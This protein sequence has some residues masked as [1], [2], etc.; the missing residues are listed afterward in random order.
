MPLTPDPIADCLAVIRRNWTAVPRVGIVLGTGL[1]AFVEQMQIEAAFERG[2]LPHFP[3]AT[4]MS[5]RGRLVCGH[6]DDLPIVVMD[7]RFHI[8]EGHSLDLITLPVRLMRSMGIELLILTNASGGLNPDFHTGD[9]V[10][11]TDHLNFMGTN[12][13]IGPNDDRFGPRFPDI[14]ETYSLAHRE[15]AANVA[16][17]VGIPLRQG[18]YAAVTGPNYETRAEIRFFRMAGADVIGMSTV[19]EALV[20][21]HASLPVLAFSVVTNECLAPA[22]APVRGEDVIAVANAAAER[23]Q[24]LLLGVLSSIGKLPR[25]PG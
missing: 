9:I 24:S 7:G 6:V 16:D 13:L 1:G 8:Y 3:A 5:H 19:P 17:A 21:A 14:S 11:L 4:A 2:D 12:P 18:V 22:S 10:M 15:L 20:A 23:L 25:T